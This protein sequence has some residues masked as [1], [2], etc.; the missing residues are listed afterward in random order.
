MT[1]SLAVRRL[2][3]ALFILLPSSLIPLVSGCGGGGP[4]T[5]PVTG[6]VTYQGNPLPK[7]AITFYPASG[8]PAY[9][10]IVDG[11]IVDVTLLKPGDG[12]IPGPNKVSITSV[13]P[14]KDMYTPSKSLIP[15]RYADPSKSGLTAEIKKGQTNE[16]K[17]DLKD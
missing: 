12:A 6:T 13:E 5:A 4:E 11:K 15:D 7:G 16:V 2:A 1:W 17:F 8:R 3:T 9:G 10:K 14:G